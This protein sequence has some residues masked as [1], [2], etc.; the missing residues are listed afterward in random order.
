MS[1][2]VAGT[3]SV[4]RSMAVAA[5]MLRCGG[6]LGLTRAG[7]GALVLL[8]LLGP[9]ASLSRGAGWAFDPEIHLLGF[10]V[11]SMGAIRSGLAEQRENRLDTYL[12]VNFLSRREHALGVVISLIVSWAAV[13]VT[14]IVAS[15]AA[16]ADLRLALWA[17]GAL[18]A[19]TALLLPIV[20]LA[21]ATTRL[22]VPFL[23][24]VLLA[25]A[26]AISLSVLA[27]EGLMLRVLGSPGAPGDLRALP[28]LF[29]RAAAV[30]VPGF[31]LY[32]VL[33]AIQD[34]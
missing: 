27:G 31:G 25:V 5:Y 10:L 15:V 2:V 32:L 18:A 33:A 20:P 34:R 23:L 14:G 8:T 28:P 30:A 12:K 7:L 19:R 13:C 16:S 22:R 3:A 4:A 26:G 11:G 17:T 24:P 9:L 29:A 6:R 1:R 21:E